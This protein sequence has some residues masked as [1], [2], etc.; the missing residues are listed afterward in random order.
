MLVNPLLEAKGAVWW[1]TDDYASPNLS[2]SSMGE[3]FNLVL[4]KPVQIGSVWVFNPEDKRSP[5]YIS[6]FMEE[7]TKDEI[8]SQSK[9][10]FR[11]PPKIRLN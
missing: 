2:K 5:V 8:E 1:H 6:V 10:K 9:Y 3:F 11:L 7:T 4:S